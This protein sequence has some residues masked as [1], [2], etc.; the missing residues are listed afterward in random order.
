MR[1]F[2]P[3]K[4]MMNEESQKFHRVQT[5][6]W[7]LASHCSLFELNYRR[8][9]CRQRFALSLARS[10][11]DPLTARVVSS[12]KRMTVSFSW[13]RSFFQ[14]AMR[15]GPPLGLLTLNFHNLI[16]HN[17]FFHGKVDKTPRNP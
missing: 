1:L 2:H 5:S 7:V 16:F 3:D 15:N 11:S 8:Y 17:E 4:A 13:S 6:S 10:G 9:S 12:A 14:D